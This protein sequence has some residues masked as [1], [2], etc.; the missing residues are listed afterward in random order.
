MSL[1]PILLEQMDH[2]YGPNARTNVQK[3]AHVTRKQHLWI[4]L[5]FSEASTILL[6]RFN[7]R[8]LHCTVE[9]FSRSSRQL[10]TFTRLTVLFVLM[11]GSAKNGGVPEKKKWVT[12]TVATYTRRL[13]WHIDLRR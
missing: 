2:G 11:D 8:G 7:S 4:R 6:T 3:K 10:W 5:S 1:H 9:L 12:V 13:V